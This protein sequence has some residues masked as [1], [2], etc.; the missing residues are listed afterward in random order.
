MHYRVDGAPFSFGPGFVLGLSDEQAAPRRH[1]LAPASRG[2]T[3]LRT[4]QFKVGEIVEVIAGDIGRVG[5]ELLS[6]LEPEEAEPA[7]ASRRRRAAG[8]R[9]G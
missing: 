9:A 3:V 2:F 6:P 4:V 7:P 1:H 8:D 5:P